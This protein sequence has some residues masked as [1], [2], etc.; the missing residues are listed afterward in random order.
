MEYEYNNIHSSARRVTRVT[1]LSE[2]TDLA[3]RME[4]P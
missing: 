1:T 3:L 4:N 2:A